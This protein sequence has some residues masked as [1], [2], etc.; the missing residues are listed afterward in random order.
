MMEFFKRLCLAALGHDPAERRFCWSC[1]WLVTAVRFS[2]PTAR[3]GQRCRSGGG[4]NVVGPWGLLQSFADLIQ[5]FAV[6]EPIIPCRRQTR[7]VLSPGPGGHRGA[8]A[9]PP[10]R[11]IPV[12]RGLDDRRQSMSAFSTSSPISSLM[13]YGVDHGGLVV[14]LENTRSLPRYARPP[15]MVVLRGVDRLLRY[16]H[17]FSLM[18]GSLKPVCNRRCAE[19]NGNYGMFNWYWFSLFPTFRD[20]FRV[21][22]GG[23]QP[24]AVSTWWRPSPSSSRAFGG[25]SIPRPRSCCSS[26]ASTSRSPQC[27]RMGDHP[28]PRR[29]AAARSRVAPF[30][31]DPGRDLVSRSRPSSCFFMF[32]M[33]KAIV[34]RYRYDQLMPPGLEGVPAGLPGHGRD[35]RRRYC[36]TRGLAPR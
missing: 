31:L 14:E 25:S 21:G 3:S 28:V 7:G 18:A 10:G 4:P 35:R 36:N 32:A 24:A 12:L 17:G 23:D 5:G 2:T 16:D 30:T 1:S 27:A 11:V 15:Q 6:K 13:V 26:S 19:R 9:P 29:L 22:L 34:P 8:R 33:V 20:L